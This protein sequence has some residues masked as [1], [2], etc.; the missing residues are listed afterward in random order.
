MFRSVLFFGLTSTYHQNE[1]SAQ[2]LKLKEMPVTPL[3][4]SKVVEVTGN[5]A[6]IVFDGYV[7]VLKRDNGEW[8]AFEV[9]GMANT[10][11]SLHYAAMYLPTMSIEQLSAGHL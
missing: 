10:E 7:V 2:M 8:R 1:K 11:R 6:S 4:L 5:G 3:L 9:T